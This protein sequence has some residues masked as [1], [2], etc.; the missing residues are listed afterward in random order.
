VP[1]WKT[2]RLNPW[3]YR[4]PSAVIDWHRR[5]LVP[6]GAQ[7]TSDPRCD[8]CT[9]LLSAG[10]LRRS[11]SRDLANDFTPFF[12]TSSLARAL[13]HPRHG[14]FYEGK[15]LRR[16]AAQIHPGGVFAMWSDDPPRRNFC[17]ARSS[18]REFQAHIVQFH[19]PL[20]NCDAASTVYVAQTARAAP[21]SVPA[22]GSL[23]SGATNKRDPFRHGRFPDCT[24]RGGSA[25]PPN[26]RRFASKLTSR[27]F[28]SFR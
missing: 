9:R 12:W 2:Q 8:S 3:S 22:R 26:R 5:G 23:N 25:N 21:A 18:V 28:H 20:L 1:R 16:L 24:A 19:N 10:G 7:L 14:S 4:S 11:R 27:E 17:N 13:L 15:A 6:L